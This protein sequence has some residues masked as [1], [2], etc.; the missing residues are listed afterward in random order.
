MSNPYEQIIIGAGFA[1]ICM[2]I[3]LKEAG[4]TNFVILERNSHL[5]GT[6]WD[7]SYPGAACDVE[8]HLY[9]YSFEPNPNWSRQFSP[10][11]EILHYLEHCVFKYNLQHYIQYNV[12]ITSA[13]FN[14]AEGKWA[15]KDRGG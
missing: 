3:R 5:G 14:E 11:E 12:T 4:M 6:W 1:G 9:S 10:Q 13:V 2:A 8:S 7:N 15:V